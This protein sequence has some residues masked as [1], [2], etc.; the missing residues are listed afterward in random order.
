MDLI[1]S[2]PLEGQV[3]GKTGLGS[4]YLMNEHAQFLIET[5][6]AWNKMHDPL[7]D[8]AITAFNY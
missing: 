1:P 3:G 8:S 6:K 5:Y 4:G 2:E 7:S